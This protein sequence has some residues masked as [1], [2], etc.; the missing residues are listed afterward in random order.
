MAMAALN[1]NSVTDRGDMENILVHK[2]AFTAMVR[3]KSV[4]LTA[5]EAAGLKKEW[6][7][8]A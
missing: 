8:H 7:G 2:N 5:A 1:V 6:S 4:A 3:A